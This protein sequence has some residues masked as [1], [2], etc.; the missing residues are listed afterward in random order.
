MRRGQSVIDEELVVQIRRRFFHDHWRIGTIA[1]ELGVHPDAVSR[2]IGSTAFNRVRSE[3]RQRLIDPYLGL[4][5]TTLREHPRLRA[6]RIF[7]MVRAR[8]YRGSMVQLRRVVRGLRPAPS[9]EPFLRLRALPGE[10]AQVDWASFGTVTVGRAKR[11]LCC[12]VMVLSYSRALYVEFFLGDDLSSFLIGHVHAFAAFGGVV[13]SVL[14]DNLKSAVIAR[15]GEQVAFHPRYLELAG[16]YCFAPQPCRPRRANEKGR[17]ERAIGY[18]RTSFFA[19]RAFHSLSDLNEQARRWV[20]DFALHRPWPDDPGRR[21]GEVFVE[22]QMRLHPLPQQPPATATPR[23]VCS[24]KTIYVRF[25]GNDY[26]IPPAAL[27]RPLTL[28]ADPTTIRLLDGAAEVARHKRSYDRYQRIEDQAH[29]EQVLTIKRRALAA[30]TPT[31][32]AQEVPELE[33]FLTAAFQQGEIPGQVTRQLTILLG[34]YGA[35]ALRASLLAALERG[36]PRLASVRYLLERDRRHHPQSRRIDLGDRPHLQ[37]LHVKPHDLEIY[38][39]PGD[40]DPA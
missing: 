27:G 2:A 36:T 30:T 13:R 29:T 39:D 7:E 5:E 32:L 17:V 33:A 34:L 9:R 20:A 31:V 4:I 18:V 15:R 11:R 37:D 28:L 38:D 16:H 10:Q 23:G 8:G 25:D 40:T 19:A 22:E 14:H 1:T 35:H 12:F 26:S 24:R 21:V 3:T 6:T